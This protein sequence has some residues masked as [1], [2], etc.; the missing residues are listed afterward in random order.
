MNRCEP[1]PAKKARVPIGQPIPSNMRLDLKRNRGARRYIDVE[2]EGTPRIPEGPSGD[3]PPA[4]GDEDEPE[5]MTDEGAEAEW[6]VV[7]EAPLEPPAQRRRRSV[8][9]T[10]EPELERFSNVSGSDIVSPILQDGQAAAPAWA[11]ARN[12]K[13][14][15]LKSSGRRRFRRESR[16]FM[17]VKTNSAFCRS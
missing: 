12:S 10:S 14:V 6:E 7:Q 15:S 11:T 5:V 1:L 13:T 3:E 17:S 4:D 16:Q 9:T 2:R 8:S